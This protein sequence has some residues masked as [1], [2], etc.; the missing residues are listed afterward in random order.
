VEL[1]GR[2]L[3]EAFAEALPATS[4]V[5]E[6]ALIDPAMLVEFEAVA[7]VDR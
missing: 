7:V 5:E 1:T 2:A 6:S 3:C 4:M